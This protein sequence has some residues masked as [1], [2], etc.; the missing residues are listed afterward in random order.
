MTVRDRRLSGLEL[1]QLFLF[2]GWD[3]ADL[4]GVAAYAEG[5]RRRKGDLLFLEGEEARHLFV[6]A[7]G[8][9][10]MF[11]IRPDGGEVTLH[12]LAAPALVACAALFLDRAYPANARVISG[13]ARLVA[14][15]GGPFLG[16]LDLRPDLARRM[17]AALAGRIAELANSLDSRGGR[18]APA[19]VAGWLMA[20][21]AEKAG[22]GGTTRAGAGRAG[23]VEIPSSK[24][25]LATTL[26]MTPETLSRALARL[27]ADGVIEVVGRRVEIADPAAL[28]LVAEG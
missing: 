23:A 3:A 6:L 12:V 16:L 19:R 20:Q 22:V 1:A 17:I 24:R 27:R 10:E 13:E 18:S 8:R 9:V 15:P 4:A 25:A 5:W 14:V 11:R 21:P 2:R 28:A 7:E 26:G